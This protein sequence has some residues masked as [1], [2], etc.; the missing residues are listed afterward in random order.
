LKLWTHFREF[1]YC[2]IPWQCVNWE[3]SCYVSTDGRTDMTNLIVTL[4]NFVTAF[5]NYYHEVTNLNGTVTLKWHSYLYMCLICSYYEQNKYVK[6][7]IT[8]AVREQG[9]NM[10]RFSKIS[11]WFHTVAFHVILGLD[12]I[13]F[14]AVKL[15]STLHKSLQTIDHRDAV[16]E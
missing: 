1:P 4:R 7:F 10:L 9:N 12:T 5:K 8:Y 3:Q 11:L 14:S 2:K 6:L 13:L 15:N 16:Q